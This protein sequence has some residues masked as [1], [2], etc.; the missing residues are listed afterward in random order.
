MFSMTYQVPCEL[1]CLA[2]MSYMSGVHVWRW[3]LSRACRKAPPLQPPLQPRSVSA[4]RVCRASAP[5]THISAPPRAA[6][7]FYAQKTTTKQ[8]GARPGH[9]LQPASVGVPV[10]AGAHLRSAGLRHTRVHISTCRCLC[11][12]TSVY[13]C[14]YVCI[15]ICM[16]MCL[17]CTYPCLY[18]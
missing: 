7:I 15:D 4:V 8:P 3:A 6:C 18:L 1:P 17:V 9:Q 5:C 13:V 10:H 12:D 2:Y 11:L 16:S 14:V